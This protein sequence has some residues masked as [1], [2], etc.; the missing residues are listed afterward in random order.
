MGATPVLVDC[1]DGFVIDVDQVEDAITDR[2]K[3]ILPVHYT[4]NVADMPAINKIAERHG[5][6]VFEDACQALGAAYDS[7]PVGSWGLA[8]PQE[9]TGSL[10]YAAPSA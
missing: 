8:N 7:E 1:D 6:L 3:A 9:P 5:L 4:G 10:S 2:T